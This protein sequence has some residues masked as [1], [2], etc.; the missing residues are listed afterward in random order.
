MVTA[1]VK[2]G[3]RT[4]PHQAYIKPPKIPKPGKLIII[5]YLKSTRDVAPGR[6]KIISGRFT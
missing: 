1:A 4:P 3:N 6:I 5:C 2:G